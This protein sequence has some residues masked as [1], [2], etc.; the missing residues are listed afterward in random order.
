MGA[1]PTTPLPVNPPRVSIL[2]SVPPTCSPIRKSSTAP[3]VSVGVSPIRAQP[4][5]TI[6]RTFVSRGLSPI[7]F[8][9]L[10][11][12]DIATFF[13]GLETQIT[14]ASYPP[15]WP[16][17]VI[18][19]T[20]DTSSVTESESETNEPLLRSKTRAR[21]PEIIPETQVWSDEEVPV[22]LYLLVSCMY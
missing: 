21:S 19:Q 4:T 14:Q 3:H 18:P 15:I 11:P 22:R 6:M 10:L 7:P 17:K 20:T 5:P 1:R 8:E 13:N 16:A 12:P 2:S 9:E